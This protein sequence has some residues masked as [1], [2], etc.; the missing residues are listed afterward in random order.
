MTSTAMMMQRAPLLKNNLAAS[1][2]SLLRRSVCRMSS[3]HRSVAVR[4][5]TPTEQKVNTSHFV[6][7]ASA[8]R[9]YG[10]PG[11]VIIRLGCRVWARTP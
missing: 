4:A 9:V 11:D 2:S 1:R 8:C 3:S 7:N 5:Q 10:M 6:F